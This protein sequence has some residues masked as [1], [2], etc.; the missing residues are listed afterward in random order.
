MW[1]VA[2]G[3]IGWK[4]YNC[5]GSGPPLP[6]MFAHILSWISHLVAHPGMG[7]THVNGIG[8]RFQG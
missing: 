3:S 2:F 4:F 6:I 1:A 8:V 5:P 7:M